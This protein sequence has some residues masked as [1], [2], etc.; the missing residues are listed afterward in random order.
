M[1]VIERRVRRGGGGRQRSETRLARLRLEE[2]V[3]N[4]PSFSRVV[5]RSVGRRGGRRDVDELVR[6]PPRLHH[7]FLSDIVQGEF[8]KLHQVRTV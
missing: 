3:L 4:S 2:R 8:E 5:V 7:E 1:E 6:P